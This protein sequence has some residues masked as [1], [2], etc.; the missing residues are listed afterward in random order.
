[1]SDEN[2]KVRLDQ[3][4]DDLIDLSA[5]ILKYR[6]GIAMGLQPPEGHENYNA[7]EQ[8]RILEITKPLIQGHKQTRLIEA[9]S[10]RDVVKLLTQGK[11]N[12]EEAQSLMALMNTKTEIEE[13]E[14]E[15]RLKEKFL[16]MV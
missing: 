1:M 14:I 15:I 4:V 13:K 5:T 16:S 11:I 7:K 6:A 8:L 9:E 2:K 12:I 3:V 10:T